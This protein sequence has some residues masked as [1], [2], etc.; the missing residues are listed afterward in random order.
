M[1]TRIIEKISYIYLIL[2]LGFLCGLK[3]IAY[4]ADEEGYYDYF[5]TSLTFSYSELL[6][7]S[8]FLFLLLIKFLSNLGLNQS[9]ILI[10]FSLASAIPIIHYGKTKSETYFFLL[11]YSSLLLWLHVYVQIRMGLAFSIFLIGLSFY[12]K[13][14]IFSSLL[15]S[16]S[17]FTHLLMLLV[18]ILYI[19]ASIIPYPKSKYKEISYLIIAFF[20]SFY[21]EKII[22]I[23]PNEKLSIYLKLKEE[24]IFS[25]H[26]MFAISPALMGITLLFI[27]FSKKNIYQIEK[28]KKYIFLSYISFFSFY[29]FSFLPVMAYRIH[30]LFSFFFLILISKYYKHNLIFKIIFFTFTLLSLRNGLLLLSGATA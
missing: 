16:A 17:I 15:I 25:S 3:D 4:W 13:N 19:F 27:I 1:K 2:F 5:L 6:E 10:L 26:N 7:Y 30:E 22:E 20:A 14:I 29:T 11:I 24:G 9:A 18:F 8:D 12:K 21:F 28:D 23:I